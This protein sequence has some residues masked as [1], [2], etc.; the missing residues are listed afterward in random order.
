MFTEMAYTANEIFG[1]REYVPVLLASNWLFGLVWVAINFDLY[2]ISVCGH[3]YTCAV[4]HVCKCAKAVYHGCCKPHSSTF[5][6]ACRGSI[7]MLSERS[8]V[9]VCSLFYEQ[10]SISNKKKKYTKNKYTNVSGWFTQRNDQRQLQH[11]VCLVHFLQVCCTNSCENVLLLL[12]PYFMLLPF[13]GMLRWCL[14]AIAYSHNDVIAMMV[15]K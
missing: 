7:E 5:S 4:V 3:V 6:M 9:Y 15:R 12:L 13:D 14:S 2:P 1:A 8:F 11:K 10:V